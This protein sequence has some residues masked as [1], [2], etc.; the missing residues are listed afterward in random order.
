[1]DTSKLTD[2]NRWERMMVGY[3]FYHRKLANLITHFIGVP[4]ILG[5]IFIPLTWLSLDPITLGGAT[6]TFNAAW[7]FALLLVGFYYTLDKQLA[8]QSVPFM[9]LLLLISTSIGELGQRSSGII[10]LCGFFGGYILQFIGH[11]IE[12]RKPAMAGG[13]PISAMLT[14][15]LFIIA[16]TVFRFGFR[17]AL[18]DKMNSGIEQLDE[19]GEK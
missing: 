18:L 11:A 3:G 14:A 1:M 8:L 15:P 4:V 2:H 13:N 12:G 6:L 5:S 9:L 19:A 7:I 17:Q 16:E 10:A